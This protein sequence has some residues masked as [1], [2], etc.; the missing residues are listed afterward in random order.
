MREVGIRVLKAKL[1]EFVALARSGERVLITEH[2]RR[3]A[4]I[5]PIGRS[6]DDQAMWNLVDAGL[7]SWGG[8]KPA[9]PAERV[10]ISGPGLSRTVIEDREDRT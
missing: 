1:S 4:E 2:G 9:L 8:R 10:P 6:P 7:A 3:V 5:V